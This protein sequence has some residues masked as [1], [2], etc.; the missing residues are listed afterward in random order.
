MSFALVFISYLVTFNYIPPP[1]KNN[2]YKSCP[3][4]QDLRD[5]FDVLSSNWEHLF[6]LAEKFMHVGDVNRTKRDYQEGLERLDQWL[7]KAEGTL[8]TPQKV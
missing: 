6:Q 8:S 3:S 7:R 5:R 1:K 2:L 4:F